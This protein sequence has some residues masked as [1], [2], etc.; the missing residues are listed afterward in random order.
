MEESA[1]Y[2][3]NEDFNIK[4]YENTINALEFFNI[5]YLKNFGHDLHHNNNFLLKIKNN[6]FSIINLKRL[7][8]ELNFNSSIA[9]DKG[10]LYFL[11][12]RE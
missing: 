4:I 9:I 11:N 8:Y 10:N 6:L 3:N 5:N 7:T 1:N 2:F 12:F